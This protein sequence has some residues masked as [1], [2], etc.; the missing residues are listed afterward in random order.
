MI[1]CFL[2]AIESGGPTAYLFRS[3]ANHQRVSSLVY[4][5]VSVLMWFFLRLWIN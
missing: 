1:I 5:V 3:Q 4:Q 2:T